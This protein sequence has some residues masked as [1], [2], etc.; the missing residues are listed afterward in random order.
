MGQ[1]SQSGGSSGGLSLSEG[2][3]FGATALPAVG[4]IVG[5]IGQ[6]QADQYKASELQLAAQEGE[7]KATQTNAQL[8]QRLNMT[9]GNIDAVRAASHDDPSSPTGAA[10]RGEVEATDTNKKN[11][12]V[13]SILEQSSMDESQ[14]AYLRNA[15]SVALLSGGI[16]AGAGLMKGAAGLPALSG[17]V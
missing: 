8:T 17:G 5:A 9:L 6:S 7:V 4:S 10:V 3:S 14:A 13:D 15:S 2:L 12:Q 16:G 1:G 11:I